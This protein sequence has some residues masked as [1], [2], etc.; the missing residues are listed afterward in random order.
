[1]SEI[2]EVDFEKQ[3]DSQ[4]EFDFISLTN[5]FRRSASLAPS[6]YQP[7]RVLFNIVIFISQ[8]E[9]RHFID[10]KPYSF[11]EGSLV[12]I[13]K[14][15]V[16][17]FESNPKYK[18]FILAFTKNF[19]TKNI[20]QSDARSL[21]RLYNYYLGTP[22]IEPSSAGIKIIRSLINE[23]RKEF[24]SSDDFAKEE[25]LSLLTRVLLLKAERIKKTLLPA[26]NVREFKPF[27]ALQDLLESHIT[28]S[29]KAQF[30]AEKL[31]VS[32]K[33]LNDICK[34]VTK[35]T[36]KEFIDQHLILEI[37]RL[38]VASDLSIKELGY[39]MNFEEPTNFVNF[40]K[41]HVG[42]SPAQF[43]KEQFSSI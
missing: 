3:N 11:K 15:Q 41:K 2:P 6:I 4:L 24:E 19:I 38:L 10:F 20:I 42:V 39:K 37:K 8:G 12:F 5:L 9:G 17:A 29:R 13:S 7:H 22:V 40:F 18:G 33:H 28:T 32:Y 27:E 23:L 31:G 35:T 14:G 16:H 34:I 43:R 26:E 30:Y 1:M 21:N 36:A 25:I